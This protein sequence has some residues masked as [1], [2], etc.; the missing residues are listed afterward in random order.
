LAEQ[1]YGITQ[2]FVVLLRIETSI[3]SSETYYVAKDDDYLGYLYNLPDEEKT[4]V[5][6]AAT[7]AIEE[8]EVHQHPKFQSMLAEIF[9]DAYK[10]YNVHFIIETHSEYIVRK[11]QL[12]VAKHIV[13]REDIS[14]L[15]VYNTDDKPLYEPQV[16]QIKI[17][18]D[19]MLDGTFGEGFFEE[20]DM[21]TML[22]LTAGK[23]DNE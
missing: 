6:K 23:E 1:G 17:R 3:M 14:I 20:A 15:Y 9:V 2:L 22:L 8:P 10:N 18:K 12:L 21:L 13:D 11:L 7:L 5:R 19:G 4:L 16:K